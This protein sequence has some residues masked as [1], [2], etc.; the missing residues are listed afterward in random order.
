[1]HQG[2]AGLGEERETADFGAQKLQEEGFL[3]NII[4]VVV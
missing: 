3:I 2:V 4:V 1:M